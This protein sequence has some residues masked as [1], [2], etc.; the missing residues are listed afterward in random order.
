MACF[1]VN[2]TVVRAAG[3][4]AVRRTAPPTLERCPVDRETR[5]VYRQT[6]DK[7]YIDFYVLASSYCSD[8]RRYPLIL[9]VKIA[10]VDC[11]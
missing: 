4:R 8:L 7:L 2:P 10:P 3:P 5:A 9:F 11:Y 6:F 1:G